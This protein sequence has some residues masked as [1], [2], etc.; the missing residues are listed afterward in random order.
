[1]CAAPLHALPSAACGMYFMQRAYSA[2]S[3]VWHL[4]LS[5]PLLHTVQCLTLCLHEAHGQPRTALSCWL[6]QLL[7]IAMLC[8]A[9]AAFVSCAFQAL[10][11]LIPGVTTNVMCM[12]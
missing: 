12:A 8:A 5:S 11:V 4:S 3:A 10:L 6:F 7:R 9:R 1:M 2:W